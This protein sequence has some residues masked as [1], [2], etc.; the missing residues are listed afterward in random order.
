MSHFAD[1]KVEVKRSSLPKV[2]PLL[3]A[4]PGLKLKTD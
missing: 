4:E 3:V 2:T 1:E